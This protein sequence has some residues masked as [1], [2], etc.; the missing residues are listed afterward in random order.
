MARVNVSVAEARARGWLPAAPA[1]VR[2]RTGTRYPRPTGYPPDTDNGHQWRRDG[3][4][5]RCQCQMW[6]PFR[7]LSM[8][9]HGEWEKALE[10]P[11]A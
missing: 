1:P 9:G 6:L 11:H 4:G 10:V 2:R 8:Y 7:F 3:R 5:F